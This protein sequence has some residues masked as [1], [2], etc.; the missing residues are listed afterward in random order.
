MNEQEW[1]LSTM[2]DAVL[3]SKNDDCAL[4]AFAPSSPRSV[5]VVSDVDSSVAST[6]GDDT[7]LTAV[8]KKRKLSSTSS[9]PS[10]VGTEASSLVHKRRTVT[11]ESVPS[12]SPALPR[13]VT[14]Y[15][16]NNNYESLTPA[17][18]PTKNS[19]APRTTKKQNSTPELAKFL[20]AVAISTQEEQAQK[21]D[22]AKDAS[23]MSAEE[24]LAHRRER[25]RELAKQTRERKKNQLTSLKMQFESL[26]KENSKLQKI[27][28]QHVQE[29]K[30]KN[31]TLIQA[32]QA[33]LK[34]PENVWEVASG[35]EL[36][37]IVAHQRGQKST[38][39]A[40]E[41]P[42]VVVASNVPVPQEESAPCAVEESH[43][44]ATEQDASSSAAVEEEVLNMAVAIAHEAA[45][46][47]PLL[48][49]PV[50]EERF[51]ESPVTAI[52]DDIPNPL[53]SSES[54]VLVDPSKK[55][56]QS[57]LFGEHIMIAG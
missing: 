24:L 46:V 8:T 54:S 31:D 4:L 36:P 45:A 14:T 12:M 57:L 39:A 29:P 33:L 13:T 15:T 37:T 5:G 44:E 1:P 30:A 35:I 32:Q 42:V 48:P 18:V 16:T 27:V 40:K 28:Y 52:S 7:V 34:V 55:S 43:Q 56:P 19:C 41:E 49:E 3:S 53:K 26:M 47:T 38:K 2:T 10:S 6:G 23:S 22:S 17:V 51:Q 9:I 21:N 50:T 25:N 11:L 20:R